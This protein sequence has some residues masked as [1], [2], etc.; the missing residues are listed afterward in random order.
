M[1]WTNFKL[2]SVCIIVCFI[3]VFMLRF[4]ANPHGEWKESQLH[5]LRTWWIWNN[6][7]DAH[8]TVDCHHWHIPRNPSWVWLI[9]A[10]AVWNLCMQSKVIQIHVYRSLIRKMDVVPVSRL[11]P[12]DYCLD[13][14]SCDFNS[15]CPAASSTPHPCTKSKSTSSLSEEPS[16]LISS[17]S[18]SS[19]VGGSGSLDRSVASPAI[20]RHFTLSKWDASGTTSSPC[21]GFSTQ[22][23]WM[24]D[25]HG[26][27]Y[28][29]EVA[30][31]SAIF[32]W[33]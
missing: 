27:P 2:G 32:L 13:R 9:L 8:Y 17:A 26:L 1:I 5:S 22:Y 15:V 3:H 20:Y 24:C 7:Q 10:L 4:A 31:V 18:S 23:A 11:A 33:L 16:V 12:L 19:G 25:L 29:E 28:R 14:S 6:W 21:G 30:W